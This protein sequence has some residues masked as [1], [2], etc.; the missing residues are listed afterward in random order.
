V[1]DCT[2]TSSQDGGPAAG[3]TRPRRAEG[4]AVVPVATAV[5]CQSGGSSAAGWREEEEDGGGEAWRRT[6]EE[7]LRRV[8]AAA[9]GRA[10]QAHTAAASR[11]LRQGA[12]GPHRGPWARCTRRPAPTAPSAPRS[13]LW[14]SSGDDAGVLAAARGLEHV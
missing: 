1:Q 14:W 12:R 11:V 9:A 8:P 5:G 4:H 7:V 3:D 6:A 13:R 10:V 2:G